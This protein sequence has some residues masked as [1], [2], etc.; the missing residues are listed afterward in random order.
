MLHLSLVLLSLNL[1]LGS[2]FASKLNPISN[3]FLLSLKMVVNVP[4]P[5]V[6]SI[7]AGETMMHDLA[8]ESAPEPHLIVAPDTTLFCHGLVLISADPALA[9]VL[10]IGW[11]AIIEDSLT[12][13]PSLDI[14][15]MSIAPEA[16]FLLGMH[17]L[18]PF[19]VILGA[20]VF[21]TI[22]EHAAIRP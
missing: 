1:R 4:Q 10:T 20:E 17:L 2:S 6:E 18:M 21:V 13:T 15:M 19:P 7:C 5:L 22:V 16:L 12:W 11:L 8:T 9:E 14:D 3:L